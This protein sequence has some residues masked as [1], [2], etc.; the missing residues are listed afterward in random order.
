MSDGVK[1]KVSSGLDVLVFYIFLSILLITIDQFA[2]VKLVSAKVLSAKKLENSDKLLV[3]TLFDGERERT[4]VSGIAKHYSPE[5]MV[6]KTVTLV[7]NLKPAKLRGVISEGM[8]LCAENEKGEL[9]LVAP[10]K[11]FDAGCEIR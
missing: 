6:G 8:I 4:V 11:P 10:E 7:A 1:K 5:E 9:S 2:T 3:M